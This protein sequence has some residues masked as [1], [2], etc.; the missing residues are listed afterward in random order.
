MYLLDTNIIS[1][2]R[3]SRPHGALLAWLKSV[4]DALLFLSAVSVGE[5]Q[6]GIE[7][8]R[9]QDADRAS[10]IESWLDQ[11]IATYKVLDMDA[12]AFRTWSRLMMGK[13]DSLIEDAMIAA[14]AVV[15]KLTIITRNVKDFERF[16]VP[17]LDPFKERSP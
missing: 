9:R 14:T 8:T 5:I 7:I 11:I 1:E 13:P 2:L 10:E 4:D 17:V 15:H 3:R 6:R 16:E 12:P